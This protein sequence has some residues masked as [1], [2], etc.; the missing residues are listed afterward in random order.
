[1]IVAAFQ[2]TEFRQNSQMPFADQR[3]AVAGLLQQG[4]QRGMLRRQTDV[5][6]RTERLFEPDA[7]P[8]LVAARD[9]C[10]SRRRAHRGVGVR[11]EEPHAL[12]RKPVDVRRA[13]IAAPV[14]GN[15]GIAEIV[16][17]DEDDVRTPRLS[18]GILNA[19]GE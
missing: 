15:I 7:Q 11:L 12:R 19:L 18:E 2:R 3:R 10:G 16:R 17:H 6:C 9:Q 8:V 5:G 14:A 1:M 13:E 4:R